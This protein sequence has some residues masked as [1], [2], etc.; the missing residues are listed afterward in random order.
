M[1]WLEK[2]ALAGDCCETAVECEES[3]ADFETVVWICREKYKWER[4]D[5]VV[6]Y[7]G[8]FCECAK[9]F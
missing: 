6:G 8:I 2:D 1:S 7:T 3:V 4:E 9:Q 5:K